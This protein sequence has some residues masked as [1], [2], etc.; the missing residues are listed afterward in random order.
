VVARPTRWGNP[1]DWQV[2]GKPEA[3]RQY[4]EALLGGRLPYTVADVRRELAGRP[5]CCW[6]KL[7]EACHADALLEVANEGQP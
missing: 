7:G 5:L 4:R 2:I 1:F 6:C 3:V